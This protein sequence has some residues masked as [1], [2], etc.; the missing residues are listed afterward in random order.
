MN[1]KRLTSHLRSR[2]AWHR[3]LRF[4]CT[5]TDAELMCA[6]VWNGRDYRTHWIEL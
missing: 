5:R 1:A 3:W 4:V 6:T 2:R